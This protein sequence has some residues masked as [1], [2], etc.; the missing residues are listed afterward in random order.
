MVDDQKTSASN[1]NSK[2]KLWDQFL[3][4]LDEKIGKNTVDRWVRTLKLVRFDALNIY[5]ETEDSFQISFFEEHIRPFLKKW[6]LN[7]GRPIKVNLTTSKGAKE[8][9]K[10]TFQSPALS[11]G[12][13]PIDPEMTIENFVVQKSQN[14]MAYQLIQEAAKCPFN[15]VLIYGPQGS[16]KT[17]LMMAA[18]KILREVRRNVFYVTADTFT[19][20]VVTGIRTSNMQMVRS[21]Y[22]SQDAL[23]VDDI[24]VF[25]KRNATQEEFFHTFNDLHTRGCLILLSSK[26][27][28]TKL[29]DIEPR[30]VSRFEW[31][32][33][34][35]IEKEDLSLIL[36]KKAS[37]W[38]LSLDPSLIPMLT[39]VF[40]ISALLALQTLAIR[41]KDATLTPALAG[42]LLK[43]LM[44]KEAISSWT[45]EKIC[46]AVAK[47]Y[48][49]LPE[50][51]LSKSQSREIALPRQVAMYLCR[52]RLKLPYQKI[53]TFFGR[54]HSTVMS[55]IRQI[56]NAGLDLQNIL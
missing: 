17:H 30:L 52:E 53:G 27:A 37:I 2:V 15:P 14:Q 34:L 19:D 38:K 28:P 13:D 23:I 47:H 50:D 54:D 12:P 11:I 36:E 25:S 35:C 18:A 40:P 46:Q 43:D 20:H 33:S 16:G 48:G 51:I 49:I 41:A 10:K 8:Q 7:N 56:A 4:Q 29:I 31:G 26:L 45:P 39:Q 9:A 1:R 5:L 6:L 44:E 3:T 32:I 21:T 22:R 24:D 42:A 55:S